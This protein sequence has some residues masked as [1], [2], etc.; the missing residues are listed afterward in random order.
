MIKK[1]GFIRATGVSTYTLE[2][3]E[4]AINSGVWDVI[5]LP[6]NLMNQTQEAIF[7]L[8]ADKGI[9]VMVRS[10]L[11]KGI[12]SEKGRNLHSELK[13]VEQHIKLYEE[14]YTHSVSD[15]A[16]LAIKFALSYD[17]VSSVLVGIDRM[18]YLQKSLVVA[19]GIYMDNETLLRARE[20]QYPDP[21]FLDLSKW[22][23]R[24][25]LT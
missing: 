14:L 11:F 17:Q 1:K 12:L 23:K 7:S 9:G 3:S 15:L 18:D 13:D 22:D 20:L 6:F 24:G 4:M 25:W 8:A 19:D 10:V 5:Q 2:E 21:Q 16:S